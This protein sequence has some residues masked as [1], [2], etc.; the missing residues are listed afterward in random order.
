MESELCFA[1]MIFT[2]ENKGVLMLLSEV[3]LLE[4][5]LGVEPFIVYL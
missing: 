2:Q 3:A 4:H 5:L 1:L